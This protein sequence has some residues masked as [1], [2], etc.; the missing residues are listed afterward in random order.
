MD[1]REKKKGKDEGAARFDRLPNAILCRCRPV[2]RRLTASD[3]TGSI[4]GAIRNA[5]D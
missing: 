5:S 2:Y 1:R 4:I 3:G